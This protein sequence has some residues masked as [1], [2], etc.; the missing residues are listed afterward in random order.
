MEAVN[1]KGKGRAEYFEGKLLFSLRRER[2]S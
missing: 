2:E 1:L